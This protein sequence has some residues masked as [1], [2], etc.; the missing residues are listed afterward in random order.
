MMVAFSAFAIVYGTSDSFVYLLPV[1][2]GFSIWIGIGFAG[3][4]ARLP[5]HLTL[6]FS[7][8]FV[9][10]LFLTVGNHWRSVDASHDL[11]AEAFGM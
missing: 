11:R 4:I 1:C 8:A 2:L 10:F 9:L 3:I 5:R 6:F 7:L